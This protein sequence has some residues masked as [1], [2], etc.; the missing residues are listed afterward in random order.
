VA[1]QITSD[2]RR[3]P[4]APKPGRM[5]QSPRLSAASPPLRQISWV[6]RF[7]KVKEETAQRA[8]DT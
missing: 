5:P 7:A 6:M 4:F 8:G 2:C 3:T 1:N